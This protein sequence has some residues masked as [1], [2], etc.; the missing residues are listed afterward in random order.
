MLVLALLTLCYSCSSPQENKQ[1][2]TLHTAQ[3]PSGIGLQLYTLRDSM[4]VS[5]KETLQR[6]AKLGYTQIELA[7][8]KEGR[9]YGFEPKDFTRIAKSYGLTPV[10][11]HIGIEALRSKPELVISSCKV[12]GISY[13]VLPWLQE[14]ERQNIEQY[15]EHVA[16]MNRI[17]KMCSEAGLKFAYHNHAFEFES[18]DGE[19][20][21]D[22]I[23]EGTNPEHVKMELDLYWISKAGFDPVT[24]LQKY[25][26]RFTMWHV[27]D[28]DDTPDQNFTEVGNGT[29]DYQA[30]F[31][32]IESSD[33]EYF[34]VEQ[35]QSS[36]PLG[37]IE[38]SIQYL[39]KTLL[40]Q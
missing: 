8:Y 28:M 19:V 29:I 11:A 26:G 1:E 30:I 3:A 25:P 22:I 17:G 32:L 12:A 35:D 31:E 27:K 10:S 7:D 14:E 37:S 9:F 18:I 40:T 33:L 4:S 36:N 23:M 34:F 15:K 20:P 16:L 2:A 6:V 39:K 38:T 21:M 24:Y 13:V 5:P